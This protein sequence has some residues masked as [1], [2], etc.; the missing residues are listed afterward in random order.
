[1]SLWDLCI[2]RPV[3][4][5]ML[6][7]APIVLGLVGRSRL[8]VDLLPNVDMPI[9]V[10][11]T[12]LKGA[13]VEEMETS[14][15]KPIEQIINTVSG[16]DE[17][18]S[19]T[20][21]GISQVV[22]QFFLEKSRD[23]AAQEVR[24]KVST[25]VAQL[26]VG[27]D[28]PIIDKVDLN[29][30]PVMQIAVSGQRPMQEITEIARKKIKEDLESV[31]GVGA[32][33]IVGGRAR[34]VNIYIDTDKLGS[35]NLSIEDVRQALIRQNLE[36]PGGRVDQGSRELVLR[37][38]GRVEKTS[39]FLELIVANHNGYPVRIKDIG[40]VED[41]F[42]EPRSLAR[43]DGRNAV[44]LIVQKQSGSNTVEVVEKVKR[45]FVQ[46]QELLP[47][48]IETF[49]VKDQSKFIVSSI[50]ELNFHLVVAALLVAVTILV[51]IQD[52]RTTIIASLAIPAS[53]VAT[54]AFLYWMGYT[55]NNMTM[56][57]LILAIG[58]VIDDAVVINENIFRHMEEH[59]WSAL[60]A[61][62]S[63]TQE[64]ALAVSATTLSLLVIFLPIVFMG[65]RVGRFFSSFGATVA[66]AILMSWFVSF[67]MTPMLCS[68]FLKL[69]HRPGGSSKENFVW[70]AIDSSYGWILGWSL[71]HRW[72]IVTTTVALFLATFYLFR[73]V[74][75]DFIPRDDQSEFEVAITLPE[76]YSLEQ[77]D[78]MFAEIEGQLAKLRG[79][80]HV[81]SSIGDTTG[82]VSRGQGDVTGGTIYARLVDL[83]ERTRKWYDW[84]F[85]VDGLLNRPESDPRYYAQFDVQREARKAMEDYPDLRS[86]VQDA[87][88]VSGAGFKQAMIDL[89]LR[90]P[91]LN[92]LVRYSD[93]IMLW[94]RQDPEYG[95]LAEAGP[96]GTRGVPVTVVRKTGPAEQAGIR[97]GDVVTAIQQQEVRTPDQIDRLLRG[98]KPGDRVEVVLDRQGQSQTVALTLGSASPYVDIDTSLS[99][100]KPELRVKIDRE[101][102]SDL[103]I[104]VVAIASTL[105]VLVGGEPVTKYKE[106]DEQYDVWLRAEL[107]YRDRAD[108]IGRLMVPSPK[109]GLVQIS[110]LATLTPAKGPAAID[111]YGMQRQVV[112]NANLEGDKALG[113][114][115]TDISS[116]VDSLSLPADYRYEFLGKAKVMGESNQ[117]FLI[118][119]LTSFLFM[120]M[121]LAAQFESFVHPITILL[122]LPL[123]LPFALISLILLR[124]N[125]NLYAMF[126]L[127]MLFGIVKKNGILQ[128]DFT[129]VLRRRGVP[130]DEAILEANHTRLRPILM[131]T[132]MLIAAMIPIAL[133]RGPGAASRAS[134]AK[135]ILGGQTL[136]LL[137]TLLVTPVA[138]SL[139]EDVSYYAKRL[140]PRFGRSEEA[141][142]EEVTL[143]ERTSPDA[144]QA[145]DVCH[146]DERGASA[147]PL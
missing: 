85:W 112:I 25:I 59:G 39:G 131:T 57:G 49:V 72:V 82:R 50:E 42:E 38:M 135:V 63:A 130:R 41:T 139:W 146:L 81:F 32:V 44:S 54:F 10:V 28:P 67:T 69:K 21:E 106:L 123:T 77:G 46:L 80:Q 30:M 137:L 133:G 76:G 103:G 75:F 104:P 17:M 61:A 126:G 35:L 3:F 121:I 31:S 125:L 110:S 122:A 4:T 98:S 58:I 118:A 97:P 70:Q 90:G 134:L 26:P 117:N 124:T 15:T 91:D 5:V 99:L 47:P 36:L 89:N 9:V 119:F 93:Q 127:F 107:P 8:G 129:N 87:A 27:T 142:A 94:L 16:I 74:G 84:R 2:K 45:R 109:A 113:D 7:S 140:F 114:A 116:L 147:P 92:R 111:R 144:E 86:A 11:T 132:V 95:F 102:A 66:F 19:T 115:V 1:M 101:K 13:S 108:A 14:V 6:V 68:R 55:L 37:T 60:K 78:K 18:R 71:R 52:W 120:Y 96:E 128:V 136:S 53:I 43:L 62:S 79:V 145:G 51:F 48:D 29:A 64:I 40:R 56:L 88:V 23:V 73:I 100:R 141:T 105:N 34:A 83:A 12:T 143:P 20:K 24:D 22:V 33:I 138:Y 65:G